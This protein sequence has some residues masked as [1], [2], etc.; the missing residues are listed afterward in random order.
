MRQQGA[1][2]WLKNDITHRGITAWLLTGLLLAFYLLLY[3]GGKQIENFLLLRTLGF[4]TLAN[5][6]VFTPPDPIGRLAE[7]ANAALGLSTLTRWSI[8]GFIYTVAIVTGGIYVISKYR[9]N[10]YQI[11]RTGVVMFIQISLAFA[12]PEILKI[13]D[14]PALY[15]SYLWPLEISML[16]PSTLGQ[17]PAYFAVWAIVGSLVVAPVLGIF[18]GKRW[19]CSWVCGCGGLANTAGEPFRHLT[20]TSS[21]SWKFEKIAIHT[22][23]VLA[24][25]ATGFVALSALPVADQYPWLQK[26]AESFRSWYG[27]IFVTMISGILGVVLY[28][29]GGTRVWCRNFCP[30]AAVLGLV[31]KFG[32]YRITVKDDMCISCGLCSKYCEMG[33]D[34][35]A[36]AQAQGEAEP[37]TAD[38][39]ETAT[40]PAAGA[41]APAPQGGPPAEGIGSTQAT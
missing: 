28:P 11:V 16:Y 10:A 5:T 18:F 32:R 40:E 41:Q 12:I 20:P 33:I 8:Y 9:D 15:F 4:E 7:M 26:T 38:A 13:F 35:R 23:L 39:A 31:Q 19:Y 25:L 24:L 30:M 37:A 29:I 1:I 6:L 3:Y 21:S 36:Y 34:V 2:G 22:T 27:F 17:Y 14:Q